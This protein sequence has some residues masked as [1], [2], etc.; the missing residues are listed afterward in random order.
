[1]IYKE[2]ESVKDTEKQGT[3]LVT[4]E[5]VASFNEASLYE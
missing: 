1:M 5:I 3:F 2:G 4:A